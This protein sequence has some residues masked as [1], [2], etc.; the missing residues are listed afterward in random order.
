MQMQG[1]NR[2]H[3]RTTSE[4]PVYMQSIARS[5]QVYDANSFPLWSMQPSFRD[6]DHAT[7]PDARRLPAADSIRVAATMRVY[8]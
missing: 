6:A 8:E 2:H 7:M 3:K 5:A 1:L 4:P